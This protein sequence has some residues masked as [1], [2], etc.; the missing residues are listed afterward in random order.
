MLT[1]RT[2]SILASTVTGDDSIL[3]IKVH[4]AV[5]LFAAFTAHAL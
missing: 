1:P 4:I 3:Y 5:M 2:I